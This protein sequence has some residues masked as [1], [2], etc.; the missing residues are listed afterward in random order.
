MIYTEI[1]EK[2][3]S[4]GAASYDK[5]ATFQKYAAGEL[6][7][8]IFSRTPELPPGAKILELGC[9][10]GFLTKRLFT[11]FPEA[12]ITVTDISGQMLELCKA[13]TNGV[14]VWKKHF[15]KC[16]F[17]ENIP[18]GN[19]DLI[20]SSL[21]FQWVLN[22]RRLAERMSILLSPGGAVF[23]SMLIEPT[24]GTLRK[25]FSDLNIPYP[26]PRFLTE[27]DI[28]KTFMVFNDNIFGSDLHREYYPSTIAFLKHL[29]SIGSGNATG[30]T[31]SVGTLR[32]VIEYHSRKN[33]VS[34]K[35]RA[36]YKLLYGICRNKPPELASF[37]SNEVN[38]K[39][40]E[41]RAVSPKPPPQNG[42]LGEPSL[43]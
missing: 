40:A 19:Y 12:E 5:T 11:Q 22:L 29:N 31:L 16:D 32:K 33:F 15:M 9:G 14:K 24:F 1:I 34:G 41:G 13:N 8:K 26:G 23:F 38:F 20:V 2:N 18:V 7:K 42:R 10:T 6:A 36:D 35:I 28:E 4:K 30:E 3:F 27:S 21:S 37:S 43:P 17:E 39:I 25:S